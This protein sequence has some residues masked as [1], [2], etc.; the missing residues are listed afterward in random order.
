MRLSEY[1]AVCLWRV[2][3]WKF[4]LSNI[5]QQIFRDSSIAAYLTLKVL[6][7]YISIT[8]WDFT[9][10]KLKRRLEFLPGER[11]YRKINEI[12]YL[13]LIKS[14]LKRQMHIAGEAVIVIEL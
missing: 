9:P 10:C 6:R 14:T 7:I 8:E 12:F 3:P 1:T 11:C 2:V 13:C 5:Q 4:A